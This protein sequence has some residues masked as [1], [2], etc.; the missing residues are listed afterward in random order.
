[1][2]LEN[3]YKFNQSP[4]KTLR[5]SSLKNLPTIIAST[6]LL[7]LIV[8]MFKYIPNSEIDNINDFKYLFREKNKIK[9]FSELLGKQSNLIKVCQF[10]LI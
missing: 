3:D 10:F 4:R 1:M 6:L 5:F 2:I 9:Y 7:I 8:F